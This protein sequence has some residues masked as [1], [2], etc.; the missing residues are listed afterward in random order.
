MC[1]LLG[2]DVICQMGV[3]RYASLLL[4]KLSLAMGMQGGGCGNGCKVVALHACALLSR[5]ALHYVGTNG[6]SLPFI[7]ASGGHEE[8]CEGLRCT[9]VGCCQGTCYIFVGRNG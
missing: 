8:P 5:R 3:R 7:S 6:G 2:P 4:V 1:V 9:K